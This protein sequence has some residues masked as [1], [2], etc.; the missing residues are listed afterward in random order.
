MGCHT[1]RPPTNAASDDSADGGRDLEDVG[2]GL[3]VE[4][5][6]LGESA[7]F[8]PCAF[9]NACQTHL[10]FTLRDE[11]GRVLAADRDG[12]DAAEL[13][14]LKAYSAVCQLGSTTYW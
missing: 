12:G 6:V 11:H 13:M 1:E 2:D 4:Q 10:N 7:A 14:A 8:L 9:C 3:G 5:L